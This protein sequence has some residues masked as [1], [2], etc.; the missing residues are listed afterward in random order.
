MPFIRPLLMGEAY[1]AVGDE[2]STLFYNPAGPDG[3]R[4]GSVEL[5]GPQVTVNDPVKIALTDA[6][7]FE[8]KLDQLTEDI[9]NENFD[10]VLNR[11][12]FSDVQ[13]R[14]PFLV[15]PD[16]GFAIGLGAEG[17]GKIQVLGNR[18]IPQV[19]V[20]FFLDELF[21]V[22]GF[23]RIGDNL[24]I[25]IL[26]K[27]INRIGVDRTYTA[28]DFIVT[29]GSDNFL[30]SRPEW[31]RVQDGKGFL[32]GGVDVGFIY[33]LPFARLW[34]PRI[35]FAALNIGGYDREE[36]LLKGIEFGP[37]ETEFSP[38]QAGELR[39]INTLGFAVS[40]WW[41]GVRYTLAVDVV[42]VSRTALPGPSYERRLRVG[43]EIGIFPHQDGTARLSL[44]AGWNGGHKS[45]GLL[46]RV[47]IFEIGFGVYTVELGEKF[48][49]FPDERTVFTLG[50]RF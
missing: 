16:S 14:L 5:F 2:A 13:L 41:L 23:G 30:E 33:R 44:L 32:N 34:D 42:D 10:A 17:L 25:G 29:A 37:R 20:E 47:F 8:N 35:G 48:G 39:Q 27:V 6:D 9:R 15:F 43:T 40:P 38:P 11:T 12:F 28:G 21:F 18:V 50:I 31:K 3:M 22:G 24:S 46:A 4:A 45:L 7:K 26:A 1:V 49:D 36:G 19:R